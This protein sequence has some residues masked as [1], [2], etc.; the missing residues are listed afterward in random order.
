MP[1][2]KFT[3]TGT[4]NNKQSSFVTYTQDM[5]NTWESLLKSLGYKEIN[6]TKEDLIY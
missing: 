3:I 2:Y 1:T 6:V 5:A 4:L